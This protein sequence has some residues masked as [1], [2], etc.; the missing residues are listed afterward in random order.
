MIII[1]YLQMNQILTL[2]ISYADKQIKQTKSNIT[3]ISVKCK[4]SQV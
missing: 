2:K 3:I 1:K 4:P